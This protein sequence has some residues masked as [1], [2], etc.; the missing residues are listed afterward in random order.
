MEFT[1]VKC[2]RCG[3][4]VSNTV[5]VEKTLIVRAFVECPECLE[6]FKGVY[7][8]C[9]ETISAA[10]AGEPELDG[11]D[12][13]WERC[14]AMIAR[15]KQSDT[16]R[17]QAYLKRIYFDYREASGLTIYEQ[18]YAMR[19]EAKAALDSTTEESWRPEADALKAEGKARKEQ[20]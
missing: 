20:Q 12:T 14:A 5:V 4:A 8:Q 16:E 17:L 18:A 3:E 1:Q 2:S 13:L 19:S 6:K 9:C 10:M 15:L 7:E 11:A